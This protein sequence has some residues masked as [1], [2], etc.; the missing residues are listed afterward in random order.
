MTSTG[1]NA[2]EEDDAAVD[3]PEEDDGN[4]P[5]S[6]RLTTE[7][8]AHRALALREAVTDDPDVALRAA[9]HALCLKLFYHYGFDT[10]LE[11]EAKSVLFGHTSGLADTSVAKPIDARRQACRRDIW[12]LTRHRRRPVVACSYSVDISRLTSTAYSVRQGRRCLSAS[13]AR[14]RRTIGAS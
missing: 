2:D 6:D 7:L 8:T 3:E 9:L 10:C 12:C 4:R 14:H 13:A 11:I 1:A 5:L